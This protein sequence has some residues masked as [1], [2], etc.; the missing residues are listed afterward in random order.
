[1]LSGG[2]MIV[3]TLKS[4]VE[5]G[6]P[7]FGTRML[8]VLFKLMEPMGPARAKTERWPFEAVN[9]EAPVRPRPQPPCCG[10]GRGVPYRSGRLSR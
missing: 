9:V 8:Y 10:H 4:V 1:M 6:K 2:K 3:S 5:T 7:A